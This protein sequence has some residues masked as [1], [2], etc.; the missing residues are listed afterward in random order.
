[1]NEFL[2]MGGYGGYVWS[3]YAIFM[4]FLL[5]DFIAPRLR[6]RRVIAELRGR[7]K[8]ERKRQEKNP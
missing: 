8:R 7:L 4:L 3:S 1:M 2:A 6:N 5:F